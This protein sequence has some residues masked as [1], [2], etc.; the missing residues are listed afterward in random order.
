MGTQILSANFDGANMIY[1]RMEQAQE[2]TGEIG[3]VDYLLRARY[4]YPHGNMGSNN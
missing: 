4:L 2:S 1:V 3:V